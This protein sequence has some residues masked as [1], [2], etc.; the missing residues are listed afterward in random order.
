L[1]IKLVGKTGHTLKKTTKAVRTNRSVK[2]M[3]VSKRVKT[4]EVA[5]A[6]KEDVGDPGVIPRRQGERGPA[7]RPDGAPP[8]VLR[9]NIGG[10]VRPSGNP[11]STI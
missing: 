9:R 5:L 8:P 3:K 7:V 11:G 4:A 6:Q 2:V 10:G 1:A